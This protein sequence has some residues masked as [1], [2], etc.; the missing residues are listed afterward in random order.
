MRVQRESIGV[1]VKEKPS[2]VDDQQRNCF[3]RF[4]ETP[5]KTSSRL[6]T[7]FQKET[8]TQKKK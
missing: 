1:S 6:S 2:P 3:P 5:N 8:N 4:F 7:L